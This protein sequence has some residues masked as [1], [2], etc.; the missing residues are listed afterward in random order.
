MPKSPTASPVETCPFK[1]TYKPRRYGPPGLAPS[2]HFKLIIFC[3][4]ASLL[5]LPSGSEPLDS[6]RGLSVIAP[7]LKER[8]Q[9]GLE[10][11]P[12]ILVSEHNK[13]VLLA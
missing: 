2:K 3:R 9:R 6:Q 5:H 11:R 4:L 13:S 1:L 8:A 7:A 10:K 12:A